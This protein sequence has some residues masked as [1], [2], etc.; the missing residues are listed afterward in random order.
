[1]ICRYGV[2]AI[3][4]CDQGTEFDGDF[5]NL[6]AHYGIIQRWI[7]SLNPRAN[8]L[9][10]RYNREV[11]QGLQRLLDHVQGA[12]WYEVLPDV[13]LALRLLPTITTGCSAYELVYK[14]AP[15][16]PVPITVHASAIEEAP[17]DWTTV[18]PSVMHR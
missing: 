13:M 4:R 18:D 11:K 17:L 12:K 10:E 16:L 15:T 8:G 6:C 3:V 7:S 2:P 1:M 14:Q 5:S 9:I